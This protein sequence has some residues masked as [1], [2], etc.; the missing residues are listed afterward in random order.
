MKV[1][2]YSA[3]T[4]FGRRA[5]RSMGIGPEVSSCWKVEGGSI[6]MLEFSRASC[7]EEGRCS[8][9]RGYVWKLS[10]TTNNVITTINPNP[11]QQPHQ[12][13]HHL[14]NDV[15][16]INNNLTII[17]TQL[18]IITRRSGG[19]H[20]FNITQTKIRVWPLHPSNYILLSTFVSKVK[21]N[22]R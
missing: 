18:I 3:R 1:C 9:R 6:I 14:K 4:L 22:F 2:I 21:T 13:L 16:S 8:V 5:L 19:W 10:I 17:L 11:Y 7:P 12:H 15:T 20:L